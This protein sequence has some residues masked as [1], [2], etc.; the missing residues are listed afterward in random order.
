MLV[1][2]FI[3]STSKAQG[4]K[5]RPFLKLTETKPKFSC[6]APETKVKA[7]FIKP[8]TQQLGKDLRRFNAIYKM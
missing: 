1:H 4:N 7:V 6:V 5:K 2:T 8:R 3:T